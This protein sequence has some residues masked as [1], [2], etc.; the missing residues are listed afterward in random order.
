MDRRDFIALA[1][2]VVACWPRSVRAQQATKRWQVGFLYPGPKAAASQRIR[3]VITGLQA[4]GLRLQDQFSVAPGLT[5]GN[6]ALLGS[7]AA[8]LVTRPMDLILAVGPAAVQAARDATSTIP[9]VAIDLESDPIAR[10]FISSIARPGRN[11]TGI[12]LDFPD[13]SKKW[14]ELLKETIPSAS[15]I[16]IFW[17]PASG[18]LQLRA[19]EA[20]ALSLNLGAL[21]HEVGTSAHLERAFQATNAQRADALLILPSPLVGGSSKSLAELATAHR[22]P[23][24]TLFTDFARQGGLLAYGPNLLTSY[25]QLGVLIAKLLKGANA[26]EMPVE[27]PTKFEFVLNLNT[28]EAFGITV[29]PPILLRADEVIE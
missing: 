3:A 24:I 6:V 19:A 28:A 8:E 11:I 4:S 10:G 18:E 20:A 1:V 12:F 14:L 5:D 2:G 26:A 13:F 23:A 15:R 16:A 22:L 25:R 27:R 9:I 29:P 17:D 21:I 7:T